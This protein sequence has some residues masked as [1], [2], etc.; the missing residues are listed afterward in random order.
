MADI[1]QPLVEKNHVGVLIV[2]AGHAGTTLVTA[3]RLLSC[4][5]CDLFVLSHH[6]A[7]LAMAARLDREKVSCVLQYNHVCSS[8]CLYDDSLRE[9]VFDSALMF[10][11]KPL[12]AQ[13]LLFC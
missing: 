12:L 7:G 3:S 8:S 6:V 1:M 10:F 5:C 13:C 2:G 9:C 4:Q 11:A